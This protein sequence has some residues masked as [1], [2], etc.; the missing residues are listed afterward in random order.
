MPE[1]QREILREMMRTRNPMR[2]PAAVEKHEGHRQDRLRT[3]PNYGLHRNIERF[4]K[5]LHKHPSKAQL[6]LYE[7]LD[8]LG[9][10][11]EQ[12][13]MLKPDKLL[14]DSQSRYILDAA[15]PDLKLDFEVD[16]WWHYNDERIKKRDVVRDATLKL[17]GWRVVRIPGSSIYNHADDVKQLVSAHLKNLV[18]ENDKHW[19]R[20]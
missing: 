9:V 7:V 5:S 2:D 17:N 18:M 8:E 14:P 6:I 13:F 10:E 12:E 16:G 4:R 20:V 15:L 3:D 11:Y 19:V 1:S